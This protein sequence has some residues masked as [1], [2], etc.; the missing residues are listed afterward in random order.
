MDLS[1][2]LK[3]AGVVALTAAGF[4]ISPGVGLVVFGVL[5]I[6]AGIVTER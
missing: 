2:V 1:D 6:L 3:V 5:L 4:T